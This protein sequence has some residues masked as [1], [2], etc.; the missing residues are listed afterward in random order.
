MDQET[1]LHH[2][3]AEI[4]LF[5]EA[6]GSTRMAGRMLGWLLVCDP[7]HQSAGQLAA[8]LHASNGSISM[9][10]RMLIQ[11]GL[12]DRVSLRGDRRTYYRLRPHA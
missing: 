9:T 6:A 10:T 2:F 5:F 7:P 8:A 3:V 4:G 1:G 12:V 11:A